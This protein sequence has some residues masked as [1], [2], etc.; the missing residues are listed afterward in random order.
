VVDH[1][2]NKVSSI[3]IFPPVEE[4]HDQVVDGRAED[5]KI[6]SKS[7]PVVA[8][9]NIRVDAIARE[10]NVDALH[11]GEKVVHKICFRIVFIERVS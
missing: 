2:E 11:S 1:H 7:E 4:N 3:D 6:A 8:T 10:C 5:G 9:D